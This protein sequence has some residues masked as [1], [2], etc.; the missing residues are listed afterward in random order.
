MLSACCAGGSLV[1]AVSADGDRLLDLS[2]EYLATFLLLNPSFRLRDQEQRAS[3]GL[4]L[5]PAH[6]GDSVDVQTFV[7]VVSTISGAQSPVVLLC[8]TGPKHFGNHYT[9]VHHRIRVCAA[10]RHRG[11]GINAW[12]TQMGRLGAMNNATL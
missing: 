5:G 3:I 4:G 1:V 7:S 2:H 6:F 12:S 9:R 11:V 8:R 10:L